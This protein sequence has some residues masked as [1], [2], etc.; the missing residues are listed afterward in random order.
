MQD[1]PDRICRLLLLEDFLEL[2]IRCVSVYLFGS[3]CGGMGEL[4]MLGRQ[5]FGHFVN[6]EMG[7]HYEIRWLGAV[8]SLADWILGAC[9]LE[10]DWIIEDV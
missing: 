5:S 6:T 2:L 10:V 3:F 7:L 8:T 4:R 9:R 1:R